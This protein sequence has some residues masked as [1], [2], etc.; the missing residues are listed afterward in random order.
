M[1]IISDIPMKTCIA[2]LLL[3]TLFSSACNSNV[4][5][6][7]AFFSKAKLSGQTLAVLPGEVSYSGNLP[8]N[9][10]A[11]RVTKMENEESLKLQQAIHDDFLYHASNKTIRNKW[12]VRLLDVK[13]IN[14]RLEKSGISIHDSWRLPSDELAKIIGTDMVIRAKVQNMRYMSQAAATGINVGVSVLESVLS[15]GGSS[16]VFV[17][18]AIAGESDMD[19]SL[20]HS[21]QPNA[22][23]RFEAERKLRVRKL[24][25]Y[26]RN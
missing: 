8:K 25:V 11:D 17:P 16:S 22:I 19:L 9:W 10:D 23:A 13:L 26:V 4:Y 5:K 24:P 21:S 20:Y 1:Y 3:I 6:D 7:K 15:R 14:D 18:R 12:D 2:L